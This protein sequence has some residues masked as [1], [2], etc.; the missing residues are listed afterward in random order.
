MSD[1]VTIALDAMGGD[2]APDMVLKGASIALQRFPQVHFLVYGIESRIRP[3][4]AKL[5]RL[6]GKATLHHTDDV[7]TDDA[8]PSVALR[9]GRRSRRR[10]SRRCSKAAW[11]SRLSRERP[12][13]VNPTVIFVVYSHRSCQNSGFWVLSNGFLP[14]KWG[15]FRVVPWQSQRRRSPNRVA[16]CAARIMPSKQ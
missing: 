3:L 8:K 14:P 16:T 1:R 15:S 5:P 13:K 9:T 10:R 6:A 11:P 7:V 4:M 12:K 2:H